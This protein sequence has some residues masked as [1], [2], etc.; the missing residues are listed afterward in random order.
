MSWTSIEEDRDE[1]WND[2]LG[3]SVRIPGPAGGRYPKY[4]HLAPLKFDPLLLLGRADQL[5]P[6]SSNHSALY[7]GGEADRGEERLRLAYSWLETCCHTV[8]RQLDQYKNDK[9]TRK[10]INLFDEFISR[11]CHLLSNA[12]DKVKPSPSTRDFVELKSL[13]AKFSVVRQQYSMIYY[14]DSECSNIQYSLDIISEVT[15][16]RLCIR[17]RPVLPPIWD[18]AYALLAEC[19]HIQ[20]ELVSVSNSFFR[21][22]DETDFSYS[23]VYF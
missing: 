16:S 22:L 14:H 13:V 5:Q 6:R 23:D 21:L 17:D 1:R 12:I 18:E 7:G 10:L 3:G 11:W 9:N 4:V 20:S 2:E 15:L 8:S 19:R